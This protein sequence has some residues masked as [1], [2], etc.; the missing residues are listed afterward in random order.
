LGSLAALRYQ[1]EAARALR[2]LGRAVPRRHAGGDVFS[3]LSRRELEVLSLVGGGMTNRQIA[4]ELYLSVRTIDRHMSRIFEKLGVSSRAAA[5][6][7]LERSRQAS[8]AATG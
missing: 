1:D 3:G 4:S 5:A 6:S 2:K 7:A 8:R